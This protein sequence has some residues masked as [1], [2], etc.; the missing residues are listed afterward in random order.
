MRLKALKNEEI[1]DIRKIYKSGV[2]DSV[3]EKY[4]DFI[5]VIRADTR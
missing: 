5:E 2:S 4:L 3:I 1:T